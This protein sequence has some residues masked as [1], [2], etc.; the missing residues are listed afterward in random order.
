MKKNGFTLIEILVVVAI[1][2]ILAAVGIPAYQNYLV[3][4]RVSEGLN[5]ATSA[6]LAVYETLIANNALPS[7]QRATGYISPSATSNVASITIADQG[8]INIKFTRLAGD[9]TIILTPSVQSSGEIT[10]NCNE[11]TLASKYRPVNCR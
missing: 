9:G 1:V 4:A 11:G 2:G 3:R 6:K 5:L 10:W 8:K 7:N